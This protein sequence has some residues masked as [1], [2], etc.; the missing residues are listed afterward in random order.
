MDYPGIRSP[1]ENEELARAIKY[2]R[3]DIRKARKTLARKIV[4]LE[5]LARQALDALGANGAET[6]P[7]PPDK[8][9]EHTN[10]LT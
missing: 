9:T 8:S 3:K 1:N 7:N 2:A 4:T 10:P 6:A 5:V